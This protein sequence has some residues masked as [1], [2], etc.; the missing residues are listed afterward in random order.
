MIILYT[1]SLNIFPYVKILIGRRFY[2]DFT[3]F[4]KM[5][6]IYFLWGEIYMYLASLI[7]IQW[8]IALKLFQLMNHFTYFRRGVC[9]YY[10]F[11]DKYLIVHY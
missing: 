8:G 2:L 3:N 7:N 6:V 1:L 4:V 5:V 11:L 10:Q 9:L